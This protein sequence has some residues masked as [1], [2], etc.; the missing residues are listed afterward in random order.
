MVVDPRLAVA[1]RVDELD[2]RI[3]G[4]LQIDGRASWLRIARILGENERTVARRGARLLD[5]GAMRVTGVQLKATGT[6]LALACTPG[7]VRMC[8]RAISARPETVWA[9][10]LAGSH[11]IVAEVSYSNA[12]ETT[13]LLE[14]LPA[15]A[16]VRSSA[17]YPILRYLRTAHQWR[18]GLLTDSECEELEAAMPAGQRL[19]AGGVDGASP[20]DRLMHAALVEDGRRSYEEL[21]RL[22]GISEATAR[23]RVEQMRQNGQLVVRAVVDPA[24]LGLPTKAMIWLRTSPRELEPLCAAIEANPRIRY[25]SRITGPYQALVAADLASRA[26]LDDFLSRASWTP[27]VQAVD[28]SLVVA[29]GKRGG[30][31]ND[32]P[33]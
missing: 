2:R 27:H 17:T 32:A 15:I 4:A 31:L 18:P 26:D 7:H 20:T 14:E 16:G 1:H 10:M 33:Q 25:A 29:T 24:M 9:H 13:F 11:D 30:L 21:A 8:S 5:S 6:I 23:R 12:Q 3:I 19:R 28:V 22:A